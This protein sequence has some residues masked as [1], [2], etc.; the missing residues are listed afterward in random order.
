MA[1]YAGQNFG[2]DFQLGKIQLGNIERFRF[3]RRDV[4]NIR[5]EALVGWFFMS[6]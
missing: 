5:Y 3:M 6:P 2:I 4:W 1:R